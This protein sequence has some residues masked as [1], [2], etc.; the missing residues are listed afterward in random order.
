MDVRVQNLPNQRDAAASVPLGTAVE[1]TA[2]AQPRAEANPATPDRSKL[3]LRPLASLVP[4]VKRY[5]GRALEACGRQ[6]EA[7]R[8]LLKVRD[9]RAAALE[10]A[11]L[12]GRV[13]GAR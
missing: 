12:D 9:L 11:T 6:A 10:A 8:A 7:R 3:N 1:L 4:Y 2:T 5:R 13:A